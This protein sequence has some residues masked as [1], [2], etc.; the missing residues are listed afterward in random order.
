MN[1]IVQKRRPE[2]PG[3]NDENAETPRRATREDGLAMR[4][5]KATVNNLPLDQRMVLLLVAVEE[6]SYEQTA[7]ALD[8]PAGTVM[9]HLARARER[10]R[11]QL[12]GQGPAI[13]R[14]SR[15]CAI[16]GL[17]WSADASCRI[18]PDRLRSSCIKMGAAN[19]SRFTYTTPCP[20]VA[21]PRFVMRKRAR[22]G[23][24]IGWMAHSVTLLRENSKDGNYS[25]LP[26]MFTAPSIPDPR[27]SSR[28]RP[29]VACRVV[30][31]P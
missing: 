2:L 24:S 25:V 31:P 21:R 15:N 22:S 5:L 14:V 3:F 11:L 26:R 13:R 28:S 20:A 7:M 18:R 9:S 27:R 1:R 12:N 10:L 29:G 30:R 23:C 4:D 6:L 17:S 16:S 19:G 8:I